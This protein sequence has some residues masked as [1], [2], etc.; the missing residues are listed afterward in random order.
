ME[1]GKKIITTCTLS[2]L[3]AGGVFGGV[4]PALAA[5][6]EL[7]LEI[8]SPYDNTITKGDVEWYGAVD[9]T[10]NATVKGDDPVGNV[11]LHK[12]GAELVNEEDIEEAEWS[13]EDSFTEGDGVV[14][15]EL[16]A[17]DLEKTQ[18][19]ALD[20]TAPVVASA[21]VTQ[22][23][24]YGGV[25]YTPLTGGMTLTYTDAG[26]GM[27]SA[28]IFQADG[29]TLVHDL[30]AN[31]NFTPQGI[32]AEIGTNLNAFKVIAVDELGNTTTTTL[33]S[34]LG[35][36]SSLIVQADAENNGTINI[37]VTGA[38]KDGWYKDDAAA[39]VVIGSDRMFQSDTVRVNGQN[40]TPTPVKEDGK[41]TYNLAPEVFRG[42]ADGVYDIEA[43]TRPLFGSESVQTRKIKVDSENPVFNGI[44]VEGGQSTVV[45]SV[46]YI[47][48]ESAT[49]R[50]PISD[51]HSGLDA[52]SV[53][54]E[55]LSGGAV[56]GAQLVDGAIVVPIV[57]GDAYKFTVKDN[58]G[59]VS[60]ATMSELGIDVT[61]L[62]ADATAPTID[63]VNHPDAVFTENGHNWYNEY[64]KLAWKVSDDTLENVVVTVNGAEVYNESTS[65]D[66][67]GEVG[68]LEP[69][70]NLADYG[71]SGVYEV[72]VVATDYAGNRS[73]TSSSYYVDVTA[74]KVTGFNF[75]D[76]G[77]KEGQSITAS[78]EYGFYFQGATRVEVSVIDEGNSSGIKG[79]AYELRDGAGTVVKAGNE[80]VNAGVASIDI[81]N[82]FKG[83]V[84]ATPI[85]NVKNQGATVHPSGVITS[86]RNWHVSTTDLKINLPDPGHKDSKGQNLYNSNFEAGLE[87]TQTSAGIRQIQYG[88]GETVLGTVTADNGGSLD[89]GFSV[90]T[91]DKNLVTK[92]NGSF[93][94]DANVNDLPIWVSVMDRTGHES[95]TERIVSVDKDS[96]LISVSYDSTIESGYYPDTRVAT[97]SIEE[98]NFNPDDVI[99]GG[100]AGSL[101]SWSNN[102]GVWTAP[103][104]FSNEED[105]QWTLEYTDM[106]GN[107]GNS[108]ASEK[109]TI[110]KTAPVLDVTFDNNSA[111]NEIYYKDARTAT[112]TVTDRNFDPSGVDF[113]GSG[114]LGGWSQSGDVWSAGVSFN[115][116]GEY[117]FTVGATDKAGHRSETFTSGKFI[118]DMTDPKL[119]ILGVENG[120]SY[121]G[122]AELTVKFSDE[123][124]DEGN[125][126][127]VLTGREKGEIELKGS[128]NS[129]TGEFTTDNFPK[130]KTLDDFYS[131]SVVASDLAGNRV[132]EDRAFS[133]NRFGSKYSFLNKDYEGKYMQ[134]LPADVKMQQSS[135]DKVEVPSIKPNVL[136][137][138]APTE[139]DPKNI[140]VSETGGETSR[141]AY[142]VDIDKKVYKSDGIYQTQLFSKLAG[143]G[144][145]ESSMQQEYSFVIDSE[146]PAVIIS[147]IAEGETYKSVEQP[148]TV[149]VR[150]LSGAEKVQFSVNGKAIDFTSEKDV[151][152]MSIPAQGDVQFVA[153]VTDKAGNIATEKVDAYVT[154]SAWD[155]FIK[156]TTGKV[157]SAIAGLGLIALIAG[158]IIAL[159][160]RSKKQ[161]REDEIRAMAIAS[162]QESLG[163]N[164]TG[165]TNRSL[166]GDGSVF[167]ASALGAAGAAAVAGSI[168]DT[169][170]GD[171]PSS[172]GNEPIVEEPVADEPVG[173]HGVSMDAS[174]QDDI[175]TGMLD[176]Q[177]AGTDFLAPG[178][179]ST[180]GM[181]D[182]DSSTDLV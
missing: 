120:T 52:S 41:R 68:V 42:S 27:K 69:R 173:A 176:D 169:P 29:T 23:E 57:S 119:E 140:K 14:S 31:A 161:K 81:P 103:M 110:D 118:V 170:S 98:R 132:E 154:A 144:K 171:I 55:R 66:I 12:N 51:I 113:S 39:N 141:W 92:A 175:G 179:D 82:N 93:T 157:V 65:G 17:Y 137:G 148:V 109:F 38:L 123:Y 47:D 73:Q 158:L 61:R 13:H 174:A 90:E 124:L 91:K 126:R 136:R 112:V 26:I 143:S 127:V 107:K 153:V 168:W 142:N 7:G 166:E 164:S 95:R 21:G 104:V 182:G 79:I 97:I 130:D 70:I 83:F 10:I 139:I 19:Y 3:V 72:K 122:D 54:V 165:D 28:G 167:G 64:P 36:G 63:N 115:E 33:S 94:V 74:P 131:I 16:K 49:L 20:A 76:P 133:L 117:E 163:S 85:D 102:D 71:D 116:D 59:H 34:A 32:G 121:S 135:V 88:T 22:T 151:Y 106:A 40:V 101:G 67:P 87:V 159:V 111:A 147:G 8:T 84:N 45:G 146:A 128:M 56:S 149:E 156:S 58:V 2:V 15:Y 43:T 99:I 25:T 172:S 48:S 9:A 6:E 24:E 46:M 5:G 44:S 155:A 181:V 60:T 145:E 18:K 177:D 77:Y 178:D 80:A 105:Y 53:L 37:N 180:T 152:S 96:P 160:R 150:D 108:Y 100:A 89:G 11:T 50:V 30:A 78:D 162:S 114:S 4:N 138:G 75:I 62:V 35:F 134:E 129:K 86:D 1:L 125:T